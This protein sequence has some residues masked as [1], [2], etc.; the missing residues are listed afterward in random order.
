MGATAVFFGVFFFLYWADEFA[1]VTGILGMK[2]IRMI[3]G[4]L[5]ALI[6]V[7]YVIDGVLAFL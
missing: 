4:L 5:L 7:Q 2:T 3:V 1:K 6:S